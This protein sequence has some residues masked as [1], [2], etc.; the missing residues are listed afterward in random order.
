MQQTSDTNGRFQLWIWPNLMN[1]I[2]VRTKKRFEIN[3]NF[4]CMF[5]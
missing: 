2:L 4:K 3:M 1:R 5:N